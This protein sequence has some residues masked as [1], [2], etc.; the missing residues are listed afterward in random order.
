MKGCSVAEFDNIKA[1]KEE[2]SGLTDIRGTLLKREREV[3]SK[4]GELEVELNNIKK[5]RGFTDLELER[6][7]AVLAQLEA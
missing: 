7:R 1:V 5:L 3:E 2:I 6:K 4:F